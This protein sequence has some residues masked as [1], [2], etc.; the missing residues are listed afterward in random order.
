M[1]KL[2]K[3]YKSVLGKNKYLIP[4][5]TMIL[6]LSITIG[7]TVMVKSM[8]GT[9]TEKISIAN[10]TAEEA[11][12]NRKYDAAVA[13]YTELQ[14]KEEWPIWDIKIAEIYSVK[15][16]FVKSN[17]IL[18]K[19]YQTRNKIV[20]TKKEEKNTFEIKDREVTNYIVFT[21]LMNAENKKALEYGELFLKEYPTDKIL[22][23][24]MFTVYMVNG[25]NDKAKEIV[26]NYPRDDE[27][28][29][30]LAILARMN[31]LVDR[32]DEGFSLL[33]DAWYKDKNEVKI[34]DVISQIAYYD[35]DDILDRISKLEKKEPN[36]LAYKMWSAKI[37]SMNKESA[38]KSGELI[39]KLENEDTGNVNLMLI[40]SDMYKNTGESDKAK[41]ALEDVISNNPNSF[42]G[43]NA[44]ALQDYNDKK[45]KEAFENCEKS[46]VMNK[47]YPGNYAVLI[48]EILAKQ[49]K[50]EGAEPYFR[51][52]LYKEPFN[53]NNI[54]K[55]AEYY[56]KILKD[57]TKALYYYDLASKIRPN[58]ADIYY[59]MSLIKINNQREDDAIALLKKSI[60]IS[61]K[62]AKYHR[63][64]G[65]VYLKK[66]KNEDA[67]KE[68]KK[69]YS[70]DKN[71]ILTLNNAGCYYISIDGDTDRGMVN[72][73]AA[74][75][76]I[77]EKTSA[78]DKETI[79][80]NYD[81]IKT[82]SKTSN[83]KNGATLTI[84][85][86]KLLY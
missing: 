3:E 55:T 39:N 50:S 75:D 5:I 35:K 58:N 78:E 72:L 43:Y 20:D 24:T 49:N 73:K 71:D 1:K 12:Y 68:I 51:T 2:A 17:E 15:G 74:Y 59:K 30:D 6:C 85:D 63:A 8:M 70:I 22:L 45:Y 21:F 10:N 48:P 37:Y 69:A 26:N 42:I 25:N 61:D 79:T 13:N 64:L 54:I 19:V 32:F 27:T 4:A 81:R 44:E 7:I 28:A 14:E 38:E 41:E 67:L 29:S 66:E 31:M 65:N 23:N 40:K 82:L 36:E 57:T 33:K 60:S 47:D 80:Q 84:T 46:I 83:K 53:Y 18:E 9:K 56:E 34:F 86:L 52:A 11:F 62:T 16:D 76:G 77:N